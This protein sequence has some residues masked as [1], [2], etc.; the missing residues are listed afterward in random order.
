MRTV[1]RARF[2]RDI[3]DDQRPSGR[4]PDGAVQP[5]EPEGIVG[6]GEED[7]ARGVEHAARAAPHVDES[8]TPERVAGCARHLHDDGVA[9][10]RI[11]VLGEV[12]ERDHVAVS[13]HRHDPCLVVL[14]EVHGRWRLG[15]VD[16]VP[17]DLGPRVAVEPNDR[18]VGTGRGVGQISAC[19]DV[20]GGSGDRGQRH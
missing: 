1:R 9:D 7:I 4:R 14:V 13:I 2:S 3:L 15:A 18:E 20:P 11:A 10:T 6:A 16:L 8:L 5:A 17:P 12:A 19:D